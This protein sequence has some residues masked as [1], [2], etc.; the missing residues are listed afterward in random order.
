MFFEFFR[1]NDE[2][3]TLGISKQ[4]SAN[5]SK[6]RDFIRLLDYSYNNLA[7]KFFKHSIYTKQYH[8][9]STYPKILLQKH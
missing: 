2:K 7:S 8:T 5:L 1:F 3:D 9:K 6:T 4:K